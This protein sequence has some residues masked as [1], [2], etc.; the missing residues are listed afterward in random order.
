MVKAVV[1][2]RYLS[3]L[4]RL[5]SIHHTNMLVQKQS[6]YANWDVNRRQLDFHGVV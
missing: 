4:V 1:S 2:C 3:Q 5:I 6:C